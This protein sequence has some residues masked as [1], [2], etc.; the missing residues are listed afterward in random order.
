MPPFERYM[1]FSWC[2]GRNAGYWASAQALNYTPLAT[3]LDLFVRPCASKLHFPS[4]TPFYNCGLILGMGFS[5]SRA[6]DKDLDHLIYLEDNLKNTDWGG[7]KRDRYRREFI[8]AVD[9]ERFSPVGACFKET[10]R[11]CIKI[12][13]PK[14][15][16]LVYYWIPHFSP[17]VPHKSSV[18][19]ALQGS[20]W[21][22]AEYSWIDV[23]V[24]PVCTDLSTTVALKSSGLKRYDMGMESICYSLSVGQI[25]HQE[26]FLHEQCR[27]RN[28]SSGLFFPTIS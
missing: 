17:S 13:S 25:R 27:K 3:L 16:Q 11:L 21:M 14:N 2:W 5:A 10:H 8:T 23:K 28:S 9:K 6:L 22:W 12:F 7:R 18:F 1:A 4:Q 19:L 26:V 15:Q 20:T 24:L